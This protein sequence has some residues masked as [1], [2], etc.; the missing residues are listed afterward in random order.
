MCTGAVLLLCHPSPPP[1]PLSY[2]SQ[3]HH[4]LLEGLTEDI[5]QE[6]R[7]RSITTISL[8]LPCLMAKTHIGSFLCVLHTLRTSEEW[9]TS[10][11]PPL[12]R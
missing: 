7:H 3:N 11:L 5:I 4:H 2:V 1:S 9:G 12:D 6:D 10:L 8:S